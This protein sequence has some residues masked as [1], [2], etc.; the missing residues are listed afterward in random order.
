MGKGR[1][2]G[3]ETW[4]WTWKLLVLGLV[5]L[6]ESFTGTQAAQTSQQQYNTYTLDD[7]T[8]RVKT[9]ADFEET[10]LSPVEIQFLQQWLVPQALDWF[11]KRFQIRKPVV[12]NVKLQRSCLQSVRWGYAKV[13]QVVNASSSFETCLEYDDGQCGSATIPKTH[14]SSQV[15]CSSD[16]PLDCQTTEHGDGVEDADVLLYLTSKN[17][18][19][20]SLIPTSPSHGEYC[21][22]DQ[23]GRPIALNL[24]FCPGTFTTSLAERSRLL[25][26]TIRAILHALV[27]DKRLVGSFTDFRTGQP[28]SNPIEESYGLG[29]KTVL[30]KTAAATEAARSHF[31]CTDLPGLELENS[32]KYSNMMLLEERI[33]H[34]EAMS[35]GALK[36]R[37][38][39]VFSDLTY[40]VV[41]DTGWFVRSL[42]VAFNPATQR[43]GRSGG[44]IFATGSCDTAPSA[45]LF[46]ADPE[47]LHQDFCSVDNKVLR[48]SQTVDSTLI[49]GLT[50]GA[51]TYDQR[52]V[53][54]CKA[55]DDMDSCK[56]VVPDQIS[57]SSSVDARDVSSGIYH[58]M[59]KRGWTFGKNAGGC[60]TSTLHRRI[61]QNSSL[62]WTPSGSECHEMK[63][64]RERESGKTE[65][66]SNL[67]VKIQN[68]DGASASWVRC[69]SGQSLE[70]KDLGFL[71]GALY[72]PENAEVCSKLPDA[73]C[74]NGCSG[75][76]SCVNS[77]CQC[78]AGY[79]GADCGQIT[80]CWQTSDCGE[81]GI[82]D[83]DTSTCIYL[84]PPSPPPPPPPPVVVQPPPPAAP[85]GEVRGKA[86]VLGW[87]SNCLVFI[88]R[89]GNGEHD[90]ASEPSSVT[91]STGLYILKHGPNWSGD[92]LFID[93]EF[94]RDVA[95]L[96]VKAGSDCVDTSTGLALGQD[97]A[98]GLFEGRISPSGELSLHM[99]DLV[100]SNASTSAVLLAVAG[101]ADSSAGMLKD[102]VEIA[103]N[104][105]GSN[106]RRAFLQLAL[107]SHVHTT[108][109][110]ASTFLLGKTQTPASG[111]DIVRDLVWSKMA[112]LIVS[113]T[114]GWQRR[115]SLLATDGELSAFFNSRSEI[116]WLLREVMAETDNTEFILSTAVSD[117][118]ARM[119]SKVTEEAS[120][121]YSF[122]SD[123][124]AFEYAKYVSIA[125]LHKVGHVQ[126][127]S[128]ISNLVSTRDLSSYTMRT[129]DS[130]IRSEIDETEIPASQRTTS[131]AAGT[132]AYD[133]LEKAGKEASKSW[134]DGN[135]D[136]LLISA[137][138]AL[139]AMA[140]F[141]LILICVVKKKKLKA[142]K[143][144]PEDAEE[145]YKSF[146]AK[147]RK[148]LGHESEEERGEG[149]GE[150]E[151][152]KGGT[153]ED[154][155]HPQKSAL[156]LAFSAATTAPPMP[157]TVWKNDSMKVAGEVWMEDL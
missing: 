147:I 157:K 140:M 45:G 96:V 15:Y 151:K 104:L 103:T 143:K 52:N 33:F 115:R 95:K 83:Q 131:Q 18:P 124:V 38:G 145:Y 105:P 156:Q 20:C 152:E 150:K 59:Q 109:S 29:R 55:A 100:G 155:K 54:L 37:D 77:K 53:G 39:L 98:S 57:C 74:V 86:H 114:G 44:C 108:V 76:G 119:N 32:N 2:K 21:K 49:D 19:T 23:F 11:V 6:Q 8:L 144:L 12:G 42:N 75:Q 43:F 138:C 130:A 14:F 106:N 25:T 70:L 99:E 110:L 97:I 134:L 78:F 92:P 1:R 87:L 13:G 94:D 68:S 111:L 62:M 128:H 113:R 126:V 67:Y 121:Y 5:L 3:A 122:G 73:G 123:G 81:N 60:I 101:I 7:S 154:A 132:G 136:L 125:K 118:I 90:S 36:T 89:N 63:C 88:D 35:S 82:C 133:D 85:A 80:R 30:L 120:K 146:K 129:S 26:A 64:V 66:T 50:L 79:G 31:G 47:N 17:S 46:Q 137:A 107:E 48:N 4:A 127:R 102:A 116:L 65:F 93:E 10:A 112:R 51:C 24:N 139:G 91:D 117:T 34:G 41:E 40:S 61:Y 69:P 9:F 22:T 56:V 27:F 141:W 135:L 71:A 28:W 148:Q 142:L 72:C 58:E 153:E 149:K 84:A 16:S